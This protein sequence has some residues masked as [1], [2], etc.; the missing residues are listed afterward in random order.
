[1]ETSC[2]KAQHARL[3]VRQERKRLLHEASCACRCLYQQYCNGWVNTPWYCYALIVLNRVNLYQQCCIK[4]DVNWCSSNRQPVTV[5]PF[6]T[7]PLQENTV[8]PAPT[9]PHTHQ[10]TGGLGG[11][12]LTGW[13]ACFRYVTTT[14]SRQ[15]GLPVGT[16]LPL[17]A[18]VS[19]GGQLPQCR[20]ISA[21]GTSGVYMTNWRKI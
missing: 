20:R 15:N 14:R 18:V 9:A 11:G 4:G 21:A 7:G 10:H 5:T 19:F 17:R 12:L 3:P 1:M 8:K 6:F 13:Y 2:I 16:W